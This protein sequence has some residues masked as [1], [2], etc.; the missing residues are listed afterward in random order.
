[1]RLRRPDRAWSPGRFGRKR[2]VRINFAPASRSDLE[3]QGGGL[4]LLNLDWSFKPRSAKGGEGRPRAESAPPSSVKHAHRRRA[5]AFVLKLRRA[6]VIKVAQSEA[7]RRVA[8]VRSRQGVGARA[9]GPSRLAAVRAVV[10]TPAPDVEC[11]VERGGRVLEGPE[12]LWAG[13]LEV[14]PFD[15][16]ARS[17]SRELLGCHYLLRQEGF[18]RTKAVPHLFYLP[19]KH[20]GNTERLHAESRDKIREQIGSLTAQ[21]KRSLAAA[22]PPFCPS[23]ASKTGARSCPPSEHCKLSKVAFLGGQQL[24]IRVAE[25][26]SIPEAVSAAR[27][28][29]ERLEAAARTWR[30]STVEERH[31]LM[32]AVK[33]MKAAAAP[34]APKSI[35]A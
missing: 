19:K 25:P 15:L 34:A 22:A 20:T 2:G 13:V 29:T 10:P 21:L 24:S 33:A 7:C 35:N 5:E 23:S 8:L 11:V 28:L 31:A 1:M 14:T 16:A 3:L 12:V 4:D 26:G 30:S 6:L 18:I 32:Q 27:D 17:A 9:R